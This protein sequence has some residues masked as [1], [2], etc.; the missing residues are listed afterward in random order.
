MTGHDELE[1]RV[2]LG[3][4]AVGLDMNHGLEPKR[5]G[6]AVDLENRPNITGFPHVGVDIDLHPNERRA[7][8]DDIVL[9]RRHAVEGVFENH[10]DALVERHLAD[11]C[12]ADRV[13]FD[14]DV[15]VL[16]AARDEQQGKDEA[17]D[18]SGLKA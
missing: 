9:A 16:G 13:G 2:P 18:V 17:H 8:R 5:T 10:G 4:T 7:A 15:A 11:G 1:H 3:L 14:L 12:I 6:N